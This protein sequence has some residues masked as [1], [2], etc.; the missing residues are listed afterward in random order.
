MAAVAAL[1]GAAAAHAQIEITEVMYDPMTEIWEW[2][3]I[4]NTT[5]AAVP[6]EGWVFD[7]DDDNDLI[8]SNIPTG[9]GNT[10]VPAHG[11]AVLYNGTALEFDTSRFTNAWASGITLIGVGTPNGANFAGGLAAGGDAFGLWSSYDDY[12]ADKIPE[13]TSSPRR[14]FASAV[15]SINYDTDNGY[16]SPPEGHSIAWNGQG[17]IGDP[18]NWVSSVD[19][20]FS[21]YTSTQTFIAGANVNSI[22]DRGTPGMV[23]GGTPASGLIISEI[24]YNPDS[25]EPGWEWVEVYNNTGN[26]IDF[27][28]NPGVFDDDDDAHKTVENLTSGTIPQGTTAVLFNA[29]SNT[30]ANIEG[31]WGDAINFIPVSSWTALGNSG[32]DLVAIWPSLEAYNAAALPGTTSP[33]RTADGTLA[34][35]LYDDDPLINWPQDD[36]NGSIYLSSLANDPTIPDSWLISLV[37]EPMQVT[38]TLEDHPGDDVGSPGLLPSIAPGVPGDYN[39]NGI[40][41]AADFTYWRD[42]LGQQITLPNSDPSDMDGE[43]TTAEYNFWKSQFGNSGSGSL[44]SAAVPEPAS[45]ALVALGVGGLVIR[46]RSRRALR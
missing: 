4:R 1:V 34:A 29:A 3:E 7:D 6:L 14:T 42:R 16:P 36:G 11:V 37:G 20:E 18:A 31:A 26:L 12:F 17:S 44:T 30:L 46:R 40:V 21:A 33:R 41:D 23:P 8:F 43:V 19:S 27:G 15:T 13:A 25:P 39:D 32:G 2:V 10:S 9:L 28:A 35:V 45:I 5:G 22:A 24:M 38:D